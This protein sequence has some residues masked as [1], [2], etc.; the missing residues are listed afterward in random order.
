MRVEDN[1]LEDIGVD[2]RA[3]AFRASVRT[4]SR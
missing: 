2:F 3:W 4:A 1:F